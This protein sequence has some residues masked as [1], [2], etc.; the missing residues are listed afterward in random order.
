M[1]PVRRLSARKI[2]CEF[3][4]H[5][6]EDLWDNNLP[7]SAEDLLTRAAKLGF[8]F[9]ALTH[10]TR[11][12]FPESLQAKAQQLGILMVPSVELC[13]EGKDLLIINAPPRTVQELTRWADLRAFKADNP[14][15]AVIAP[16][17][18]HVFSGSMGTRTLKTFADCWDAVE[19]CHFYTWMLNPNIA[20]RAFAKRHG[21]TQIATSDAHSLKGFGGAYTWVTVPTDAQGNPEISWENI[22]ASIRTQDVEAT[23][24][25]IPLMTF[26][27]MLLRTFILVWE[28]RNK[29]PRKL[30]MKRQKAQ[31]LDAEPGELRLS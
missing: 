6:K 30:Y 11:I 13:L 28:C 3:H 20:T 21:V 2:K 25:P 22:L 5:S 8:D 15:T 26:S 18:H 9:V 14:Q 7:Y 1:S 4:C 10:H 16:H 24:S 31:G 23:H 29:D 19:I 27:R 17:P 12:H